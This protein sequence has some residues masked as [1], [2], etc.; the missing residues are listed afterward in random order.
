[1]TT[2]LRP[3]LWPRVQRRRRQD[4]VLRVSSVAMGGH[5]LSR[6]TILYYPRRQVLPVWKLQ[7]RRRS[8][9]LFTS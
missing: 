9:Y 5:K 4:R 2:R 7:D 6:Q 3:R 8:F 1:M